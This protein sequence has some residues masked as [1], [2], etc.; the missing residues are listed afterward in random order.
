[1]QIILYLVNLKVVR[2]SIMN[3]YSWLSRY[4]YV[5][6]VLEK[7]KVTLKR[8]LSWA[9][10]NFAIN[11]RIIPLDSLDCN[12]WMNDCIYKRTDSLGSG[13]SDHTMAENKMLVSLHCQFTSNTYF[14][15]SFHTFPFSWSCFRKMHSEL[16]LLY[17]IMAKSSPF[18][19]FGSMETLFH[20][21]PMT[22]VF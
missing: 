12:D 4:Y 10:L 1:M 15:I 8:K 19:C 6:S 18:T 3:S 7:P 9:V 13:L 14:P 20:L 16:F 11:C 2:K 5:N 17:N 22:R 21:Y